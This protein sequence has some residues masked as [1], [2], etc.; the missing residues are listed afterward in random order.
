MHAN[1]Q[2]MTD[3][4]KQIVQQKYQEKIQR[5][6]QEEEDKR[7]KKQMEEQKKA[8]SIQMPTSPSKGPIG[9][10]GK[11]KKS[12]KDMA[13]QRLQQ[14]RTTISTVQGAN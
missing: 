9:P 5:E 6:K 2:S 7:M 8:Q 10:G 11:K 13:M 14:S 12:G 1:F 3:D 4:E